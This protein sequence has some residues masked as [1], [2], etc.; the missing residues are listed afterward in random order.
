MAGVFIRRG[1]VT[2]RER[3]TQGVYCIMIE[4][5]IGCKYK[6]NN[7][8]DWQLPPEASK[9]QGKNL[10]RISEKAW[11]WQQLDLG[12]SVLQKCRTIN[13]CGCGFELPSLGYFAYGSHRKWILHSLTLGNNGGQW[14]QTPIL[15][16]KADVPAAWLPIKNA[17]LVVDGAQLTSST[18]WNTNARIVTGDELCCNISRRKWS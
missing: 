8:K 5:G 15:H 9:W 7:A 12:T 2:W 18:R 6:P 17:P 1:N 16:S 13:I 14:K 3:G 11:S 10:F 4:A